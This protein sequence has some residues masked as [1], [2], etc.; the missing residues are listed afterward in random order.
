M[1]H[2]TLRQGT[3][4]R[5]AFIRQFDQLFRQRS[6]GNGLRNCSSFAKLVIAVPGKVKGSSK[7]QCKFVVINRFGHYWIAHNFTFQI[8]SSLSRREITD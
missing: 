4:V 5:Y 8:V 3:L 2:T 1:S 6:S 7:T